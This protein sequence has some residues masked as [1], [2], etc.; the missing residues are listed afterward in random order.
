MLANNE[1]GTH[2]ADRRDRAAGAGAQGHPP[3]RRCRPG[4]AVRRSRRATRSGATSCRSAPTSSRGPRGSAPCTSGTGRTSSPSSRAATQERHRRAGTENVAGAVGLAAAYELSCAER[5]ATVA[6]LRRLRE[7][8]SKAVLAVA[9][10]ELTGHPKRAPAGP[11]LDGRPRHG[12]RVGRALARP[13]GHRL[14]GRVGLHDG[15]HRGQPRPDRD[16]LSGGGGTG[17]APPLARPDDHRGGDRRRRARSCHASSPRCVS[18]PPPSPPTRWARASWRE[19][20]PRRDVRRGRL[21]GRSG[22][23][24]RAGPRRGRR[25][26][27][28]ARRRRHLFGVQEELLLARRRRRRSPGRRAARTSRST[29]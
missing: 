17:R 19:P 6:R 7:R 26:D 11:P 28:P 27:A 14:L 15:L 22:A 3:A 1:V 20:D 9:G 18:V 29:S 24:A 10:T 5:P 23:P 2:P 21:V 25:L 16:G 4:G 13:R 8:L 12:R